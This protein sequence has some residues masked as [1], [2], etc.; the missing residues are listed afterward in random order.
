MDPASLL[1][2]LGQFVPSL[3]RWAH[4]DNAADVADKAVKGL[5]AVTGTATFEDGIAALRASPEQLVKYQEAMNALAIAQMDSE[6]KQLEA[7]NATMRAEIGSS[8]P[9]VRRARPTWLYVTA[10][11]W[12]AQMGAISWAI[13]TN[14]ASAGPLISAC[15]GLTAMWGIAL[16]VVGVYVK[17]R[18]DDKK[19]AA[20]QEAPSMIASLAALIS[21]K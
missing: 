1:L 20:G 9:Y 11:S 18:S 3:L 12:S 16:S 19:V 21:K 6:V 10:L 4:Q 14:P 15:A 17:S 5:A 2:G 7:V 8:D 13:V